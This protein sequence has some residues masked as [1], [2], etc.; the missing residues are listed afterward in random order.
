MSECKQYLKFECGAR[1]PVEGYLKE[2]F[3]NVSGSKPREKDG[4]TR[5]VVFAIPDC[6]TQ[7]VMPDGKKAPCMYGC[8]KKRASGR[9]MVRTW[10]EDDYK[11]DAPFIERIGYVV[12]CYPA[13]VDDA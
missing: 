9:K 11:P 1:L 12:T 10:P 7:P 13:V 8:P 3:R 2:P 6:P 5:L 4:R